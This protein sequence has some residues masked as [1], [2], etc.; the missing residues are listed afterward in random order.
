MNLKISTDRK[1]TD[2]KSLT[3]SSDMTVQ[4]SFTQEPRI[5]KCG[6]KLKCKNPGFIKDPSLEITMQSHHEDKA[7][8]LQLQNYECNNISLHKSHEGQG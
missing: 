3:C 4:S 7:S 5:S 1:I 2:A 6:T 8:T